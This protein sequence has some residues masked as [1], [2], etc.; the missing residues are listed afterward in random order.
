MIR[1]GYVPDKEVEPC[2]AAADVNVCPYISATQSAIVQIA[3]GFEMPVI[4]T[5]VGGLP[6]AVTDG[7]TGLIVP[8]ADP[9][10]LANAVIRYFDEDLKTVFSENVKNE[11]ERFSW[12]RTVEIVEEFYD[13]Y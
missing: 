3:F 11:A 4:A 8:H 2:F 6:E 5:D 13:R 7:R 9:D 1:D 12:D 10:A